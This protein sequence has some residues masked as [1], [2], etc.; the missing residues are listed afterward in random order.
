MSIRLPIELVCEQLGMDLNKFRTGTEQ[1]KKAKKGSNDC[2]P[3]DEKQPGQ[4][5]S[6]SSDNKP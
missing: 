5:D 1:E 4:S 6:P 3:V 2:H